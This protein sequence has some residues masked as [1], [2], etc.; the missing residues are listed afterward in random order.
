MASTAEEVPAEP[1][2][3]QEK[4]GDDE[5]RISLFTPIKT[6]K[7]R[8]NCVTV[9]RNCGDARKTDKDGVGSGQAA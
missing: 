6:R 7:G 2:D 1:I 8:A 3:N 5:V 4:A 9:G